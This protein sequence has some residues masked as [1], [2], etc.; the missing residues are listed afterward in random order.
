[1]LQRV[2]LRIDREVGRNLFSKIMSLPLRVLEARSANHWQALF[3]DVD[4]V[5]N[6][7]S[8]PTAVLAMDLP[9]AV[10]FLGIVFVIAWPVAWVLLAVFAIFMAVAW[11]AGATVSKAAEEERQKHI[12]RDGA[13]NEIVAGR[14][15]IK[16]TGLTDRMAALW[17][18]RQA[19]TVEQSIDRGQKADF[20][21]SWGQSLTIIATVAMTGVGAVAIMNQQMTIGALIAANML[22]GRLLGPFNQLVGAWRGFA[23]FRQSAARLGDVF[24][25]AED[26]HTSDVVMARPKGHIKLEDVTFSYAADGPVVA[27]TLKL[28]IAAGGLTAIMGRNGSGKTTLIKLIQ[29]L[30]TPTAGRVLIDGADI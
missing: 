17:E 4:T 5:R 18:E 14:T 24:D 3:R 16:A 8:G 19:E 23:V 21:V 1:M 13:V 28:D 30:Y 12:R 10:L 7:L 27:D 26:P 11:R 22:G 29:R 20:Y 15:T 25:E 9:F 6:T 2:A